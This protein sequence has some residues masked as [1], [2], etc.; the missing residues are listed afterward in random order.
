[1]PVGGNPGFLSGWEST[2]EGA[3]GEADGLNKNLLEFP[4]WLRGNKPG[5]YPWGLGFDPRPRSVG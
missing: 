3:C 5:W 1:M 2:R 4:L